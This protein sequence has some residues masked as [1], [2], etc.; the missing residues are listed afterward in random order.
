MVG[1]TASHIVK[2]ELIGR[3]SYGE[4]FKGYLHTKGT[5]LLRSCRRNDRTEQEVAIKEV[6]L[7]GDNVGIEEI[8]REI[9]TLCQ[10][11]SQYIVRYHESVLV[12][13]KLWIVMDFCAHGSLRQIIVTTKIFTLL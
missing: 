11:S 1:S 9:A 6:N 5:L 10:C 8:R 4:V 13:S 12:G 3:G 7:E 2:C